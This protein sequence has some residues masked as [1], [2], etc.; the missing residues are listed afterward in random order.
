M[1]MERPSIFRTAMVTFLLRHGWM[2]KRHTFQQWRHGSP[3]VKPTS[4]LYANNPIVAVLDELADP[5]AVKPAGTLIGVDAAGNYKTAT[6]KEY[7]TNLCRCFATA[8]WRRI[9]DLPLRP[10][11]EPDPL[12]SEFIHTSSRVDPGLTMKPDYQPQ[13]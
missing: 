13:C 11:V 4:L 10:G 9:L 7:P 1:Q 8:I 12:A 5:T 6:A 2:F 3:A